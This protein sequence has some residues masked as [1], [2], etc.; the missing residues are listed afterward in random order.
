VKLGTAAIVTAII[1]LS[2]NAASPVC[3]AQARPWL[4]RDKPVFSSD[5]PMRFQV[6]RREGRWRLMLMSFDP[7]G[8]HDGYTIVESLDLSSADPSGRGQLASGRYFA[9]AQYLEGG[10]WICPG[11]AQKSATYNPDEVASICYGQ[12]SADC[13]VKL[14]VSPS[15]AGTGNPAGASRRH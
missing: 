8:G 13:A 10:E 1:L 7:M 15:T 2:L 9:V 6:A 3:A 12:E 11:Y 14:T 4:C 5:H